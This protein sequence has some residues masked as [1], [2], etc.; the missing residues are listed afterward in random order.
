VAL[1]EPLRLDEVV[2]MALVTKAT[3]LQDSGRRREGVALL[4]GTILDAR[5][6]GQHMAALRGN[7]NLAAAV[8]DTD[9]RGALERVRQGMALSRRLGL[10]SF[11]FFHAG[12]A[13]SVGERLGEWAWYRE[14]IGELVEAHSDPADADWLAVCR[15]FAMAWTGEPDIVRGERLHAKSIAEHDHQ[16][17]RNTAGWLARC[18]FAAGRVDDSIRWSAAFIPYLEA[19]E[20][21]EDCAM[22]GRFA[23]HAGRLDIV[24]RIAEVIRNSLGGVVD[25]DLSSL[26]AGLAAAEGRTMDALS[27]YRSTLAG[28][29]E[30][31]CRFDVALTVL[32]MVALIGPDDPAVRAAIP[33]GREIFE[34]LG[35][36]LLV[37]RLDALVAGDVRPTRSLSP[38]PNALSEV[39]TE[40]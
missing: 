18:A 10:L 7:N 32:D 28:Y 22:H 11:D 36:R 37:E 17:E 20:S 31:G 13:V 34:S 27:L 25:H 12:N 2:A 16:T 15:D 33:E 40:R 30:N 26:H 1:A 39:P 38:R 4:E 5:A 21:V 35:A 6:H 29:R 9:P 19:G 8:V 23:L 24:R 3:A 14:A